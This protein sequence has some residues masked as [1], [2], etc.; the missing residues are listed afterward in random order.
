MNEEERKNIIEDIL[1]VKR[2]ES[3]AFSDLEV[4]SKEIKDLKG[5]SDQE[6]RSIWESWYVEWCMSRNDYKGESSDDLFEKSKSGNRV[7]NFTSKELF[8]LE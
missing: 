3:N 4:A 8:K 5:K 7:Y 6:L 1:S 2:G